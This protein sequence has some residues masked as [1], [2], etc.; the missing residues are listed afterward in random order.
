MY[1]TANRHGAQESKA[2]LGENRYIIMPYF[3]GAKIEIHKG[4][5]F[6]SEISHGLDRA[7]IAKI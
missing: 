1:P 5:Y 3:R 2:F 7:Y 4:K 6:A